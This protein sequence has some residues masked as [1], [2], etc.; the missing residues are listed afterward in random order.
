MLLPTAESRLVKNLFD[1]WKLDGPAWDW[2]VRHEAWIAWMGSLSLVV[3]VASAVAV[4]ILVRRLPEDYFLESSPTTEA[5]R[6]RHPVLRVAFLLL[7]NLLGAILLLSGI[8]MLVTPGQG[9]LTI[10]IALMLMNF[11]GKRRLEIR[12]IRVAPLNRAVN[13]IRR[14]GGKGPLLL[15]DAEDTTAE[16][17]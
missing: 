12:L 4:P 14:R 9:V 2:V 1:S 7:K 11:P 6:E 17:T 15:P 5:M 10:L 3:L 13:W 16:M 8:V